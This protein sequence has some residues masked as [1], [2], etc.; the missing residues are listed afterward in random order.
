M[1][2]PHRHRD[3]VS[4]GEAILSINAAVRKAELN[5]AMPDLGVIRMKQQ[6]SPGGPPAGL[7]IP[8][9]SDSHSPRHPQGD[10]L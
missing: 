2:T 10:S 4:R 1:K 7:S 9:K 3:E 6:F 5:K 8:E